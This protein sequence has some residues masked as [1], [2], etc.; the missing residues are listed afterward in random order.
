MPT[1]DTKMPFAATVRQFDSSGHGSL[2]FDNG[3]VIAQQI[4]SWNDS[5]GFS[6]SGTPNAGTSS[7]SSGATG[8]CGCVLGAWGA[9]PSQTVGL[10]VALAFARRLRRAKRA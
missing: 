8:A 2:V 1:F 3:K 6:D 4:N 7:G 10:V 5:Q 9:N